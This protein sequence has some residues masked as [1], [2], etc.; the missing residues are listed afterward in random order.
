MWYYWIVLGSVFLFVVGLMLVVQ[1]RY[2]RSRCVIGWPRRETKPPPRRDT[3]PPPRREQDDYLD[4][5]EPSNY[6]IEVDLDQRALLWSQRPLNPALVKIFCVMRDEYDLLE[7]FCSHYSRLVGAE[8]IIL[9][10][11]RS[12]RPDV[13]ESYRS[14]QEKGVTVV[15]VASYQG[16][17]Q[18]AAFT[19]IM[20]Q[21]AF[22]AEWL[23]P[24][25]ADMF[26]CVRTDESFDLS[27]EAWE[28]F[29]QNQDPST[30]ILQLQGEWS[31]VVHPEDPSFD[32]MADRYPRP[33]RDG[34]HF[35][36]D[37]RVTKQIYR[38]KTFVST[39][40]GNHSGRSDPPEPPVTAAPLCYFHFHETG[41][42]RQVERSALVCDGYDYISITTQTLEEQRAALQRLPTPC[43]G[44]H[45]VGHYLA[46]LEHVLSTSG[47]PSSTYDI[48][49][50]NQVCFTELS[51]LLRS[52][53]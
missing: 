52:N 36:F 28:Q 21:H 24:V 20:R 38:A 1:P 2:P 13:L 46:Y 40:N 3:K 30:T 47:L 42:A 16:N 8:N 44:L 23:V 10:D 45:R 6:H 35:R 18:G 53:I 48:H 19:A 34:T 41:Y 14:W 32:V 33:A 29:F 31:N 5:E 51:E 9:L 26:L 25:D 22:T 15:P 49:R 4:C 43:P 17:G 27:R 11:H 50:P 39:E 37:D 12:S 7:D